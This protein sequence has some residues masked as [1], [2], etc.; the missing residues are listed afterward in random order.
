MLLN[1]LCVIFYLFIFLCKGNSGDKGDDGI[2]GS[3]G[4]FGAKVSRVLYCKIRE[5]NE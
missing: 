3:P 2:T 4:I 5:F 1:K